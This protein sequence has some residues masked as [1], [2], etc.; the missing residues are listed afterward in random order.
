MTLI[1]APGWPWPRRTGAGWAQLAAVTFA[2]GLM[3]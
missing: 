2:L 1:G 3:G